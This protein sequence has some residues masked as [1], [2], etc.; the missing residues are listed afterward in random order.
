MGVSRVP[1]ERAALRPTGMP[2]AKTR[3]PPETRAGSR[4]PSWGG[5]GRRVLNGGSPEATHG[6]DSGFPRNVQHEKA[7]LALALVS[8]SASGAPAP[9]ESGRFRFHWTLPSFPRVAASSRARR[10]S[11]LRTPGAFL[12]DGEPLAGRRI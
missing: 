12:M 6:G 4:E 1:A 9:A 5:W 3:T 10:A 7:P 2:F 8:A 11:S